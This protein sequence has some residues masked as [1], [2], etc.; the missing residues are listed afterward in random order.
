MVLLCERRLWTNFV[1]YNF[2]KTSTITTG[3]FYHHGKTNEAEK[4]KNQKLIMSI[5]KIYQTNQQTLFLSYLRIRITAHLF[6][7]HNF[8]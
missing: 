7:M 2:R 5:I 6:N 8:A 4:C 1:L 3:Y